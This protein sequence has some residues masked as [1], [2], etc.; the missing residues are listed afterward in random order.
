MN[1]KNSMGWANVDA[2]GNARDYLDRNST[3][4]AIMAQRQR[5]FELAGAGFGRRILDVGCGP[6]HDAIAMARLVGN[7]GEVVGV[8]RSEAMIQ[9]AR[10]R[11]KG[12]GLPVRF[13][14]G[15]VMALPFPDHYFDGCRADRLFQHLTDPERAMAELVRVVRPGGSVVVADPDYGSAMMDVSDIHLGRRV[16][17]FLT[18]LVANPWSGRKLQAMF[19]AA[20]LDDISLCMEFRQT[21][22]AGLDEQFHLRE[23]LAL[24]EQKGLITRA[25]ATGLMAELETRSAANLFFAATAFF[26]VAGT[27]PGKE[28]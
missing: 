9:E 1:P 16:K 24:M 3:A 27:T 28:L 19:K 4:D 25:E 20:G 5:T 8:D 26:T 21:D 12:L 11:V 14:V 6:G 10:Q 18:D 23:A 7:G 13:E 22:L 17:S 2:S 15:D